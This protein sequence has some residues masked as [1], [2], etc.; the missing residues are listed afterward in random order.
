VADA[1]KSQETV[2]KAPEIPR[3]TPEDDD[4][5]TEVTVKMHVEG[6]YHALHMFMLN[7]GHD[8]GDLADVVVVDEGESP[9]HLPIPFLFDLDEGVPNEIP[10]AFRPVGDSPAP[11]VGVEPFEE[12]LR[13]GNSETYEALH[14][15]PSGADPR[16]WASSGQ[17][18]ATSRK[19]GDLIQTGPKDM[20][21]V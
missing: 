3:G 21:S 9:D 6:G 8:L 13:D 19:R 4:L 11:A 18:T 20:F 7:L 5:E 14:I 16:R 12:R 17:G 2:G 1:A 10:D 15:M